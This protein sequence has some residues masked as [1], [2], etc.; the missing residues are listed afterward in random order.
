MPELASVAWELRCFNGRSFFCTFK[1]GVVHY[2]S[3]FLDDHH[4]V[5]SWWSGPLPT[6]HRNSRLRSFWYFGY[7]SAAG[8]VLDFSYSNGLEGILFM[9]R[10][11][12][13]YRALASSSTAWAAGDYLDQGLRARAPKMST[14]ELSRFGSDFGWRWWVG[15]FLICHCNPWHLVCLMFWSATKIP[16]DKVI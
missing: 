13:V 3:N 15:S 7:P 14:L 10:R 12:H 9:S 1:G 8:F 4:Q 2:N 11:V 6:L 16:T 5:P